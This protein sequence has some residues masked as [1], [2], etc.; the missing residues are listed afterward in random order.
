MFYEHGDAGK[1][2]EHTSTLE[3]LTKERDDLYQE[4]SESYVVCARLAEVELSRS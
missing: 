1:I 2:E 4:F 3:K